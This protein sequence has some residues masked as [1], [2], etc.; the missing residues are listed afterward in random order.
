M[1]Q[2]LKNR[3]I[4]HIASFFSGVARIQGLPHIFLHEMLLDEADMPVAI[5]IGFD[6]NFVEA[7]FFDEK[8]NLEK[9]IF[10]SFQSF[11]I[12]ISDSYI[13]RIIDGLG[14]PKDGLGKIQGKIISVFQQAPPIIDREPVSTP[15]STGI[16]II[17]TNLPLGKGQRELIIGDRKLGK[18]TIVIDTVLNQRHAEPPIYCIY[19]ICGQK[20]QKLRELISLFKKH[21]AF[22]YTTIVAAPAG[23]SFAEQYLAPFV[24]CAIGEYFRDNNKDA[25]IVYDDLSKHAKTYRDISLLLERTPGREAY[26]GD[27]FS[28]HAGLLERAAKI[29]KEKGGG[30]L[31]A[32]PII[33]TQESDITSFIPTNLISITDGQIYLE[34]GLFQKG[35]LPAVNV[36]LSVS[37]VGSLAQPSILKEVVG[38]IRLALAQYKELQKLSQL[39]TIVSNE[40]QKKIHRGDLMLELL[41]QEKHTNIKWPEQVILFYTIEQGFF[42]DIE[43]KKWSNFEIL[44]LEL[45][46]NRYPDV[47]QKIKSGLF[48]EKIKIKIQEIIKDFKQEFLLL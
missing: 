27:I 12:Q 34:E 10:R 35:F 43:R 14:E 30:T 3:E 21:N 29:S 37:R 41:K 45:V 15:L 32:L 23:A 9:P 28:L 33:E 7:L 39:E 11:S 16:K 13:G 18:S 48:N 31:T 17:D 4:G 5:I 8:F 22:L 24:G 2:I 44:L 46:R 40:A 1:P 20:E 26:P 47:L 25:L 38:G 36:G 42:D 19:V 6:E